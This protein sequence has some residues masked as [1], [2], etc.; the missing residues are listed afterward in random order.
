MVFDR[1]GPFLFEH[2]LSVFC[3][4]FIFRKLSMWPVMNFI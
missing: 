4:I 1:R 2:L 3:G